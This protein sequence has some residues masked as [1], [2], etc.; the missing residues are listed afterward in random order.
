[1]SLNTFFSYRSPQTLFFSLIIPPLDLATVFY[2]IEL[3]KDIFKAVKV[4]FSTIDTFKA[5]KP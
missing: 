1:V 4:I 3:L 2:F 5:T